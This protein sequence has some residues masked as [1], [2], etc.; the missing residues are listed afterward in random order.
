MKF[1]RNEELIKELQ[2]YAVK[3]NDWN[4]NGVVN[5]I[6]DPDRYPEYFKDQEVVLKNVKEINFDS[7]EHI[8]RSKEIESIFD[9]YSGKSEW[10]N[11]FLQNADLP[12][13][14]RWRYHWKPIQVKKVIF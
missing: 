2:N 3:F 11:N 9:D 4:T 5:D 7:M 8:S 12:I 1:E 6:I 10:E 13:N 14:I